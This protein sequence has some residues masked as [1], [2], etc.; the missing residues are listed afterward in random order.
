MVLHL[1]HTAKARVPWNAWL[2]LVAHTCGTTVGGRGREARGSPRTCACGLTHL[3][4]SRVSVQ[5]GLSSPHTSA[6]CLSYQHC[7]WSGRGR[8]PFSSW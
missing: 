7:T 6:A 3:A 4:W 5:L 2:T 8:L 1:T